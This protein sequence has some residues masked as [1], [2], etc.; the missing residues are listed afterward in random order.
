VST[1]FDAM[2]GAAEECSVYNI[3]EILEST[4]GG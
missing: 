4:I 3:I 1:A 2:T